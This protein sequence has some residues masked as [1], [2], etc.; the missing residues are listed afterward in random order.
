MGY[1][2]KSILGRGHSPCKGP[3]AGHV[4]GTERHLCD[5][6]RGSKREKKKRGGRARMGQVV[7]HPVGSREDLGFDPEGGGS[8]AGLWQR[9]RGLTQVLTG[10]L[11]CNMEERTWG[12][13]A[14]AGDQ[15]HGDCTSAG[16]QV[17]G[18]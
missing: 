11:C 3:G 8:H 15:S 18:W 10:A 12:A 6:S 2:G 1:L 16:E 14:G 9:R 4:G 5:W 13:M 17:V 7:Q